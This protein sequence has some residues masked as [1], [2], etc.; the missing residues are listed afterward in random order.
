MHFWERGL[1]VSWGDA[2][3]GLDVRLY[4]AASYRDWSI[5]VGDY[6]LVVE[7]MG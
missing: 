1:V 6:G 7:V 3:V 4:M 2:I 5:G